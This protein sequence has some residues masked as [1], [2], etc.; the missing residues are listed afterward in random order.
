VLSPYKVMMFLTNPSFSSLYV[1]NLLAL[2]EV[3]VVAAAVVEAL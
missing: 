3:V 1:A 2:L